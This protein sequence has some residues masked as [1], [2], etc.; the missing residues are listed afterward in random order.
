MTTRT[1]RTG[2]KYKKKRKKKRKKKMIMKQQETITQNTEKRKT[3]WRKA[4]MI[5][6]T[7]TRC[8]SGSCKI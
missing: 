3:N 6:I 7:K 1:T 8:K 2:K 5:E 4:T